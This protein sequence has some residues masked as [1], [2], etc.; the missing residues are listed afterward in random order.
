M[1][2]TRRRCARCGGTAELLAVTD[3]VIRFARVVPIPA[4]RSGD[5]ACPECHRTF[6]TS[7]SGRVAGRLV[8]GSLCVLTGLGLGNLVFHESQPGVFES[9][10]AAVAG[11]IGVVLVALAA[12]DF[13]NDRRNAPMF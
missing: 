5:W 8:A 12:R 1:E 11:V 7:S 3:H 10:L 6:T 4:G 9:L 2:P 13:V